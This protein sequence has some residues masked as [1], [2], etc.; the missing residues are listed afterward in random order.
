M[1]RVYYRSKCCIP[2]ENHKSNLSGRSLRKPC[3]VIFP[4]SCMGRV[5]G[6][7]CKWRIRLGADK[8]RLPPKRDN[9]SARTWRAV[10]SHPVRLLVVSTCQHFIEPVVDRWVAIIDSAGSCS[11]ACK[12]G[13]HQ[14]SSIVAFWFWVPAWPR[15]VQ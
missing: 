6:C 12:S 9:L 14:S 1:N 3:P 15:L 5:T 2:K 7:T 8:T 10:L 13:H 4:H 11:S